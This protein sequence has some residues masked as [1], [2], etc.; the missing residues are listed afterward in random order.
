MALILIP[1]LT[2]GTSCSDE[3]LKSVVSTEVATDQISA[4][5][6]IYRLGDGHL[7]ATSRLRITWECPEG[8]GCLLDTPFLELVEPDRLSLVSGTVTVSFE[9]VV[10]DGI[11][12]VYEAETPSSTDAT[13]VRVVLERATGPVEFTA[14]FPEPFEILSP[15][16]GSTFSRQEGFQM[17]VS[18]ELTY[19]YIWGECI[20]DWQRVSWT[21]GTLYDF[22]AGPFDA[23]EGYEGESCD[24]TIQAYRSQDGVIDPAVDPDTS[25]IEASQKR[26]V[27]VTLS[28]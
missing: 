13:S 1:I 22:P 21:L 26:V 9:P 2:G 25:S 4:K 27:Q 11:R 8:S 20:E 3:G 15:A 7:E 24:V 14:D 5:H 18:R 19:V 12:L 16:E 23:A 6:W 17:E 10:E 28:P